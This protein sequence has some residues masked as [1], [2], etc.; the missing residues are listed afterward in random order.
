M[1]A[2]HATPE[3]ASS[4]DAPSPRRHRLARVAIA[5]TLALTLCLGLVAAG[6][7][8]PNS[9][10]GGPGNVYIHAGNASGGPGNV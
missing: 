4:V 9:A 8:V 2:I 5:A 10:S 1:L 6:S 7:V 3:T